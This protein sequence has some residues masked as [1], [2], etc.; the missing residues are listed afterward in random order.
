VSGVPDFL[1]KKQVCSTYLAD[2][3][4]SC[5]TACNSYHFQRVQ[6]ILFLVLIHWWKN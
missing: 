5:Y 1:Q 6:W 4:L 2:S 3:P